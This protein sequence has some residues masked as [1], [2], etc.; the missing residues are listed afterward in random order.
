M[1]N[2]I[3]RKFPKDLYDKFSGADNLFSTTIFVLA[4]AV[5]KVARAIRIPAFCKGQCME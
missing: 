2:T 4:S 3:L 5:L 1:Y